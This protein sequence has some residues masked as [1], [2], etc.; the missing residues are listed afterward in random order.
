[1]FLFSAGE[2]ALHVLVPPY[3]LKGFGLG[4]AAIGT[5]LAMFGVA[6]LAARL[7][8][9]MMYRLSRARMLLVLGGGLSALA[10]FLVP[11]VDSPVAIAVLMAADGFGWS[12]ATTT[13]LAA[14][15]AARP[16]GLSVGSAMGWY[17]GFTG[18][19]HTVAGL[20][21][22]LADNV[23]FDVS[24]FVLAAVPAVAA[25]IMVA[26]LPRD[27][28]AEQEAER[29]E[30]A[31]LLRHAW[32]S[33]GA[34]PIVV[35]V[36]VLLM[37]YINMVNGVIQ[38]FH[39]ILALGAGLTLTQIGLL[40]SCRSWSSSF[41]RL[42][43]GPLFSRVPARSLTFPLVVLGAASMFLLPG[44]RAWFWW[45]VPLFLATGVS[46]GLL[47]VTGSAEAFEGVGASD[48]EAGMTAAL[49]HGGL[50]LGKLSG[51]L[52]GGVVA[53][54]VGVAGMFRILP[55]ML[56]GLYSV[57]AVAARRSGAR[58]EAVAA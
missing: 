56:L 15:V 57:L 22:L 34:M 33:I 25:A 11:F 38:A 44:V 47:R 4:P 17:S 8:V 58:R 51:P 24:F 3:L 19:G 5:I 35:W 50:D 48:D 53:E 23:G 39:P 27:A 16:A 12:I 37:F 40:S 18:L 55:M 52:V 9:G 1:V 10:F 28:A 13:Q 7:P 30:R 21:G 29:P 54:I 31:S 36:G 6:S 32:R 49:L 41:S 2:S 45:Q 26:A 46:R 20:A 43:S 14:L 42:G